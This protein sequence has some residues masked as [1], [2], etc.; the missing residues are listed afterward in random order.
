MLDNAKNPIL[1]K[2]PK[3]LVAALVLAIG[4]GTLV[5]QQ[6]WL[7][8]AEPQANGAYSPPPAVVAV[9]QARL[10]TM[11]P[12]TVLP[13]TVVSVRDAVI[14]SE[15]SGKVLSVAYVGATV[16]ENDSL[17]EIDSNDAQQLVAQRRAELQRLQSLLKYHSDYYQRVGL[18]K[19]DTLGVPEVVIAELK[20]NRDTAR[21]DVERA[22]A[23]LRSAENDLART[24][25]KAPFP[26]RVVSQSIQTGEYAQVGSPIVRL[27]DTE[28]LEISARVPAALVQPIEP[29]TMLAITG[30]GKT[31][32]AP[33]RA[34]VPVG[35]A[36]SRTMELRVELKD[37][38][39]LVGSPVRVSLPSAE[40][41]QV[42]AIPRDAVVLR[43]DS[44]YVFVIDENGNAQRQDVELGYAEGDM[45]EVIGEVGPEATVVIR[46]GERLRDGQAVTWKDQAAEGSPVVSSSS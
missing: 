7:G 38:G 8:G 29:G 35:D 31:L 41:R 40:P 34:L 9:A 37:S 2:A 16:Q 33:M 32:T 18:Q 36:V 15:T 20:S 28:N 10:M 45:I 22:K 21:A 6:G 11:A 42:V 24:S 23:A 30:M 4:G 1:F 44:Q 27:V 46:G 3:F 13:G 43:S 26:G 5:W 39:L 14:A 17:A 19:S 12:H 25:I